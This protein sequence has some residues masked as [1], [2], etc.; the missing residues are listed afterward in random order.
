M[1]ASFAALLL[2][3]AASA[4]PAADRLAAKLERQTQ[5]LLDALVSGD[6]T[7]WDDLLASD[8]VYGSED[9]AVKDKA[10]LLSEVA[11]LPKRIT[12][13]IKVT[14][15]RLRP[16]GHTAIVSWV[17]E[18]TEGYHGQTIHA[19][20]QEIDTWMS[21]PTG[22]KLVAAQ[23]LAL[24]TDPPEVSLAAA[25]LDGYVGVYRLTPE[26]TYEI[27]REGN[28]LV[29]ERKRRAAAPLKAEA[30]DVFFV[31][32]DNRIRKIFQRGADGRVTG[33][34]ERRESWDIHWKR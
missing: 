3:A 22:W 25:E 5:A 2:A 20:Y 26:I 28:H 12:A 9:G 14:K 24:R 11:P 13:A 32:G 6:K 7:V 27:R 16:H 21:F 8:I 17:A 18:E 30:R 15:F 19:A 29:G 34:V 4:N 23:V 31:P 1:R 33:F 10:K